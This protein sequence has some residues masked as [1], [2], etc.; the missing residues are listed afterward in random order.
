MHLIGSLYR[1]KSLMGYAAAVWWHHLLGI[2]V[3]WG[4]EIG[5]KFLETWIGRLDI[6]VVAA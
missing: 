6:N 1:H 2:C 3:V 5:F 4:C